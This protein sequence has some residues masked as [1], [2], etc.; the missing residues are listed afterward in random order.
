MEVTHQVYDLKYNGYIPAKSITKDW[1]ITCAAWSW[2]DISKGTIGKIQTVAVNDFKTRYKRN[3][4]DDYMVVKTLLS[5]ISEADV[6]IGHNVDGHDL[7][8][9]FYRQS[10]HALPPIVPP[11]SVD[12]LKMARQIFNSSSN[13]LYH[14]AKEL[15]V[16]CKIELPHGTMHRA[17]DGDETALN[18]V[19]KYCKG[20][21]LSGASIYYKMLPYAYKHPNLAK[22]FSNS[23]ESL[24]CPACLSTEHIKYGVKGV[25]TAQGGAKYQFYRCKSCGKV[26]KGEKV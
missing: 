12:T 5:V 23:K 21:I 2:L 26:H 25:K 15:G 9:I 13:S 24:E 8:K 4:R 22:I 6:V 18:K 1:Y 10:K 19:I 16:P 7:G 14:L 3:H 20:D 11:V 17:D